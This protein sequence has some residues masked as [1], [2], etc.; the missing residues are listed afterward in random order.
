MHYLDIALLVHPGMSESTAYL[1]GARP[2]TGRRLGARPCMPHASQ[3]R[4]VR[5]H[6]C[7]PATG[8]GPVTPT[9]TRATPRAHAPAGYTLLIRNTTRVC[10]SL[11]P[12]S[13]L[14]QQSRDYCL[15][16]YTDLFIQSLSNPG[17]APNKTG[18][19]VG[20]AVGTVAGA[21]SGSGLPGPLVAP[22]RGAFAPWPCALL[23]S[24]TS[25]VTSPIRHAAPR[26]CPP[27]LPQAPADPVPPRPTSHTPPCPGSARRAAGAHRRRARAPQP[28]Q[29]AAGPGGRRQA[30]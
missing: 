26:L 6:T 25:G 14:Q 30:T 29:Q 17:R 8:A 15:Q 27:V 22:Q 20:A 10:A 11:V 3:L 12:D 18:V 16:E 23:C 5:A 21:W 28:P 4:G 2:G 7:W 9:H 19:I 24:G 13:C 1:P